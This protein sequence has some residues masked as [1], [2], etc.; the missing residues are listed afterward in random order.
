MCVFCCAVKETTLFV[1]FPPSWR[2]HGAWVK[3]EP[4]G[5]GPQVLVHV[6]IYQGSILGTYF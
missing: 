3:I 4:P 1:G 6:S 5:I 2:T